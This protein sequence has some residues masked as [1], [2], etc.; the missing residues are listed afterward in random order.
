VCYLAP[1]PQRL[2]YRRAEG[3]P[4][5]SRADSVACPI[6]DPT[7]TGTVLSDPDLP[8]LTFFARR[9][10]LGGQFVRVGLKA[11]VRSF[12]CRTKVVEGD[13]V[14][15]KGRSGGMTTI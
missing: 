7:G 15:N 13:W 6:A 14:L 3:S 10:S 5:H 1:A 8:D 9:A 11:K 12:G 2:I 4:A